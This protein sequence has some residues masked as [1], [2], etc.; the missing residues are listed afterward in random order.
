M[1]SR[2]I[3]L[4]TAVALAATGCQSMSRDRDDAAA[5]RNA[6]TSATADKNRSWSTPDESLHD[7]VHDALMEQ[8]GPKVNDV[9]VTVKGTDVFLTGSVRTQADKDQAHA[10]A[11]GVRGATSVDTSALAVQP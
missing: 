8:M 9:G 10:I 1:N 6:G 7:R 5:D 2:T 4:A 11:H 3:L